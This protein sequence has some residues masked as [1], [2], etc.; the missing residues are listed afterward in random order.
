MAIRREQV[1]AIRKHLAEV[2]ETVDKIEADYQRQMK[3]LKDYH[4]RDPTD[5]ELIEAALEKN[6]HAVHA[7]YA[8]NDEVEDNMFSSTPAAPTAVRRELGSIP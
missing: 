7:F 1:T 8:E 6:R 2:K 3:E 4:G 5:D